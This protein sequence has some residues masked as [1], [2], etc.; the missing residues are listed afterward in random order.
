MP[1]TEWVGSIS[2]ACQWTVDSGPRPD[3]WFS[4]SRDRMYPVI[5][6]A[7]ISDWSPS[8]TKSSSISKKRGSSITLYGRKDQTNVSAHSQIYLRAQGPTSHFSW[9]TKCDT[10]FRLWPYPSLSQTWVRTK[11]WS[12]NRAGRMARR[13]HPAL[14]SNSNISNFF[15]NNIEASVS[16]TYWQKRIRAFGPTET[17]LTWEGVFIIFAPI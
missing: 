15:R 7:V 17:T 1:L 9:L 6:Y 12:R 14:P 5:W 10:G 4:W 16:N 2:I 3:E 13:L 11:K 8:H